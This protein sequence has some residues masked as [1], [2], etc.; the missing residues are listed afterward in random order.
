MYKRLNFIVG[1]AIHRVCSVG[2][3]YLRTQ[4]QGVILA[5]IS[6]RDAIYRIRREMQWNVT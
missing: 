1:D 3:H 2:R 5:S 6:S 4:Q